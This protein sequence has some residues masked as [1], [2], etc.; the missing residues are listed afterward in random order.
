MVD[1]SDDIDKDPKPVNITQG[2]KGGRP[3]SPGRERREA[4]PK[5]ERSKDPERVLPNGRVSGAPRRADGFE[6]R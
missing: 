3:R 6:L 1:G 4:E 5:R 2:E